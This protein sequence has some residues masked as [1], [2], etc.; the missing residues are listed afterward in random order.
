[1]KRHLLMLLC[2]IVALTAF[3]SPPKLNTEQVF[4]GR[5]SNRKNVTIAIVERPDNY[6][7]SITI[8]NDAALV[9]SI[10]QLMMK[11]KPRAAEYNDYQDERSHYI[12][13]KVMNNGELINIGFETDPAE[14]SGTFFIRGNAKA[15]K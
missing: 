15:F 4:D 11:D 13:L 10:H 12:L 3:A 2:A 14:K 7:R 1:M 6:F 5:Y 9:K 8:K